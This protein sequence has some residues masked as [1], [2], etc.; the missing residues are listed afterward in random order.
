MSTTQDTNFIP[1]GPL[2]ELRLRKPPFWLISLVLVG[3]VATLVPLAFI[4]RARLGTS[5]E[6]RIHIFQDMGTQPKYSAQ[7]ASTVFADGRAARPVIEGTVA[8]EAVLNDDH[9]SLGYSRDAAGKISFY[10]GLPSRISLDDKLL[11]RGKERFGIYCSACHGL[12][13]HGNGMVNLRAQQVQEAGDP[14]GTSWVQPANLHDQTR[15][16]RPDGHIF[17]T[18]TNGIRNMG[19]LGSQISVDD[20]WAIVAYVRALQLSDNAPAKVLDPD[21]R[22]TMK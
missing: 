2:A 7:Q 16:E 4:A 18:I 21:V 10:A 15:R 9:Y 8:R 6:P 3:A 13:G 14:Y 22:D 12:D 17:N 5:P 19:G 11:A 20:R 1:G